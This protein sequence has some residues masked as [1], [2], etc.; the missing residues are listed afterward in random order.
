MEYEWDLSKGSFFVLDAQST[1]Q[2]TRF[3]AVHEQEAQSVVVLHI[4]MTRSALLLSRL[5]TMGHTKLSSIS[6]IH[7]FRY[8]FN[9]P[10]YMHTY[11]PSRV[12]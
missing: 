8:Y 6:S 12:V 3:R 7:M 5:D 2:E 1:G 9:H 11:F 10:V 4:F